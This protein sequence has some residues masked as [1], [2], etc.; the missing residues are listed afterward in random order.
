LNE[1]L[2]YI[3]NGLFLMMI[4]VQLEICLFKKLLQQKKVRMKIVTV[5]KIQVACM[6][7]PVLPTFAWEYMSNYAGKKNNLLEILAQ[8]N[9]A[10]M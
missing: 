2:F 5:D 7:W 8:K 4:L 6:V 3:Q 10:K 1:T 9:E